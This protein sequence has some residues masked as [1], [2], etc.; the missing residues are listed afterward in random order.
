MEKKKTTIADKIKSLRKNK[1]I[2][3][4]ELDQ[5]SDLP[6]SSTS[7]IE[8]GKREATAEE[9]IRIS[10][11]LGVSLSVFSS[12]EDSFIY[13]E[14]VKIIQALREISFEDYKHILRTIESQVYFTSKDSGL[15]KKE[16][17]QELVTSLS[18]MAIEDQRP[19]SRYAKNITRVRK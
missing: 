15:N 19:R 12:N 18:S 14:E 8:N 1:K 7:K 9:L 17:L 3:Q 2:T 5:M 13:A 4:A 11:S 16:Y 6:I 10:K